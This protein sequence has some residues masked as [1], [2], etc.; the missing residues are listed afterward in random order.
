MNQKSHHYSQNLT[1]FAKCLFGEKSVR[2]TVHSS[3]CPFDKMSVRQSVRRQNVRSAKCLSPKCLSAKCL[4]AKCP[5]TGK[6]GNETSKFSLNKLFHNDFE[7]VETD[8]YDVRGDDVGNVVMITLSN[9]GFGCKSD[10][11][12]AKII[13]EKE[14]EDG[15]NTKYEFPCY[16]WVIHHLVV[17]EGKYWKK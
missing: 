14:T 4:S 16:R 11:Y 7:C 17:Y 10:W 1:N 3:N 8:T 6:N 2:Q 15:V 5:A 9:S 12:I 13:V